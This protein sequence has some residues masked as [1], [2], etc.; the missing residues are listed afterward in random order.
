MNKKHKGR[1]RL[2]LLISVFVFC[3]IVVA[4]VVAFGLV[5]LLAYT[6]IIISINEETDPVT[7]FIFMGIVSL[8][9]GLGASLAAGKIP[10]KPM[11]RLI[12][13]IDRLASGDFKVRLKPSNALSSHPAVEKAV[14]SFNRMAEQLENTQML[15]Q[16]FI[17]NF[18]HE[19]KTPIVSI[20]GFAKL[21]KKGNLSDEQKNEYLDII[22]SESLRLS[23]MATNVLNLTKVENQT[24]LTDI[25]EYNLSEQLRNSILLLESKWADR[26]IEFDLGFDEHYIKANKEL[27]REVWINL[28]DNAIKH[29]DGYIAVRVTEDDKLT[30]EVENTGSS[31]PKDKQTRIFDKFYQSDESHSS[32]GNGIGLALAKR[33]VELHKG[34]IGVK[35][36]E[37]RVTFKVKLPK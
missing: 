34:S 37:N 4:V 28:L 26:D 35:S 6:G 32:E 8:I 5:N 17:N 7:L 16:D 29:T 25:T 18:S 1:L 15:R 9:V 12:D 3:I 19:F 14:D 24:I 36:E 20:A 10:I 23:A 31:I 33:I 13:Q 30:I 22:E 11:Y 21:L 27:L 2:S